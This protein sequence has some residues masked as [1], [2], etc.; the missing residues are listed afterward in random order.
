MRVGRSIST[1]AE[2]GI[3]RKELE[4]EAEE[5]VRKLE[6]A[7]KN[8]GFTQVYGKGWERIIELSRDNAKAIG[9]YAFFAQHIDPGCGA[10]VCDQQFLA[11]RFKVNQSTI[12]RWLSYLEDVKAIA[13]IPIAGKICAYALDPHEVWKG[14]D[15]SKDYAAFT[16]RTLVNKNNEVKRRLTVMFNAEDRQKIKKKDK[17]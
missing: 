16:T 4:L 6:E 15:T 12:S 8:R 9:L 2:R 1:D 14:Y 10:V 11:D 3:R 7:K 5:E 13:R 17:V